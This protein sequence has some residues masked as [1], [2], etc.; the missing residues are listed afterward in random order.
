MVAGTNRLGRFGRDDIVF[1]FASDLLA[2]VCSSFR[3]ASIPSGPQHTC[4]I[5]VTHA[6]GPE[7]GPVSAGDFGG[8]RWRRGDTGWVAS[9]QALRIV[10]V[11]CRGSDFLSCRTSLGGFLRHFLAHLSVRR[12][13]L[14]LHAASV[15]HGAGAFVLMAHSGGGKTT[16]ARRFGA[17][18]VLADDHSFVLPWR[19]QMWVWPSPFPGR[20]GMVVDPDP[21]PLIGMVQLARGPSTRWM[22]LPKVDRIEALMAH[23]VLFDTDTVTRQLLLDQVLRLERRVGRLEL[24]LDHDPWEALTRGL[25][26]S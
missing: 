20:E 19:N 8:V 11:A 6:T 13:G 2:M 4:T 18:G 15:V 26:F 14:S 5:R 22:A 12:G 10:D 21:M 1:E 17:G 25:A 23:A 16:F 9:G 24:D 3:A 7:S